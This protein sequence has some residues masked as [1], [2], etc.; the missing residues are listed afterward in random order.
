LKAYL[1]AIQ[2]NPKTL[3][4][5]G[6][7]VADRPKQHPLEGAPINERGGQLWSCNLA[8]S[9][10][11]FQTLGG[12]NEEFPYAAMEDLDFKKRVLDSGASTL[13]VPEALIVHPWRMLN[14]KQH[15]RRHVASQ[16]IYARLHPDEW[17][18]FSFSTHLRN[19]ARYYLRDFPSEIKEFG[20]QAI[21]CQ[22]LRWWEIAYRAWHLLAHEIRVNRSP[23]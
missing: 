14:L 5:E 15:T 22:P 17:K 3:V 4:F 9:A 23:G 8:I 11:Y 20:W 10:N 2:A 19:V 1:N 21:S 16:L 18:L 6:K 13:F 12:F 7:T